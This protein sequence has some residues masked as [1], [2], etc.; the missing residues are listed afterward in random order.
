MKIR[1]DKE[2]PV[3]VALRPVV[4]NVYK[5]K[6]T[7]INTAYGCNIYTINVRGVDVSVFGHDCTVVEE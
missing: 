4:G 3:N 6:S 5:V 2:I 1:I 7:V